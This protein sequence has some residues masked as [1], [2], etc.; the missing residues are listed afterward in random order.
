MK[1]LFT[2]LYGSILD[3]TFNS[4]IV[5]E[6]GLTEGFKELFKGW[7]QSFHKLLKDIER[8]SD[9][10]RGGI[11]FQKTS[12]LDK[13]AAQRQAEEQQLVDDKSLCFNQHAARLVI[14]TLCICLEPIF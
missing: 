9:R 14:F 8:M 2:S 6:T 5:P 4:W 1:S 12:E 7:D 10:R 11:D 13:R 3:T